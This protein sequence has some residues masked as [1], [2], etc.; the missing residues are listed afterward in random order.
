MNKPKV[1]LKNVKT[2]RGMEGIGINANVWINGVKCM[3]VYDGGDGGEMQFDENIAHENPYLITKNIKLLDDYI[4]Q[5]PPIE[6]NNTTIK[7]DLSS[8]IDE[9]LAEQEK[10]KNEAKIIKLFKD[11]IVF[12]VPNSGSYSYLKQKVPLSEFPVA[13]L[14]QAVMSIKTKY[15]TKGEEILNTNLSAL[16]VT[17]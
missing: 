8:F 17:I 16:G 6:I 3:F 9:L 10:K 11:S 5:L 14:Q 2:F 4:A 1:K 12:G 13:K 15:C 7:A